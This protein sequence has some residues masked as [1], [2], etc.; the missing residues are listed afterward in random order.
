[1]T[2]MH[3]LATPSQTASSALHPVQSPKFA[4]HISADW[5][6]L[7]GGDLGQATPPSDVYRGGTLHHSYSPG[8]FAGEAWA[9][10]I[11]HTHAAQ[12]QVHWM[13]LHPVQGGVELSGGG[14][15]LLGGQPGAAVALLARAG[16]SSAALVQPVGRD[17]SGDALAWHSPAVVVFGG[18]GVHPRSA[19]PSSPSAKGR[20]GIIA[21]QDR[22]DTLLMVP[23][24]EKGTLR[25]V[26]LVD[27]QSCRQQAAAS[28]GPMP[29]PGGTV[30]ALQPE[31]GAHIHVVMFG[32]ACSDCT[33]AAARASGLGAHEYAARGGG[34]AGLAFADVWVMKLSA[35]ALQRPGSEHTQWSP[36]HPAPSS[37]DWPAPL[38][39]SM[40]TA[41]A[42]HHDSI[43]VAGGAQC[44]PGCTDLGDIW[45]L[46]FKGGG[47]EWRLREPLSPPQCLLGGGARPPG[48]AP[49]TCAVLTQLAQAAV[50]VAS[51]DGNDKSGRG[52]VAAVARAT[53]LTADA[54]GRSFAASALR[55]ARVQRRLGC[56]T[57]ACVQGA[58]DAL[59]GAV[60]LGL[61]LPGGLPSRHPG[62]STH[63][64]SIATHPLAG[65]QLP[66][67][68]DTAPSVAACW[69]ALKGVVF[70]S[71]GESFAPY[72]SFGTGLYLSA[73]DAAVSHSD[74]VMLG[75]VGSG[76]VALRWTLGLSLLLLCV[77]LGAAARLTVRGQAAWARM[78]RLCTPRSQ[79]KQQQ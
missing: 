58:L 44:L 62:V 15:P 70:L 67:S 14:A 32:G 4:V 36:V 78:G 26:P 39:R 28:R 11:Q 65:M 21:T 63:Q 19:P 37:S 76:V 69:A 3:P 20:E 25:V 18:R 75:G 52:G 68:L 51:A 1:M 7:I 27:A 38:P 43:I 73:N 45:L 8:H 55:D 60:P 12:A 56:V 46:E 48:S 72:R 31:D 71:G 49:S 47:W 13:R 30:V 54:S 53:L 57:D 42:M 17:A 41:A 22:C 29:G 59:G 40:H 9:A 50:A 16:H 5:A 24:M 33:A 35:H 2:P 79:R 64:A 74:H 77:A 66:A 6:L 61:A 23:D 34:T 10:N